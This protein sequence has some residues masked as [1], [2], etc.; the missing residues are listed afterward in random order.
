MPDSQL[1]PFNTRETKISSTLKGSDKGLYGT[2]VN[3]EWPSLHEISLEIKRT[4]PFIN[5]MKCIIKSSKHLKK[6]EYMKNK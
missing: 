5:K 3:R 2:V 1:Y 4:V 6:I